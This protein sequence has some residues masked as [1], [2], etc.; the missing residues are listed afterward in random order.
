MA[1]HPHLLVQVQFQVYE[2]ALRLWV[3]LYSFTKTLFRLLLVFYEHPRVVL[4]KINDSAYA[5]M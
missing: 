3:C 2:L 4:V 1:P 5:K